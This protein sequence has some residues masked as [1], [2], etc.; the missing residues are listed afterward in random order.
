MTFT[1]QQTALLVEFIALSTDYDE[2]EEDELYNTSQEFLDYIEMTQEEF[3][4]YLNELLE[5]QGIDGLTRIINNY[6]EL[7]KVMY[8]PDEYPVIPEEGT[9]YI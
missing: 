5:T 6:K 4:N 1:T 3:T 9:Y 2:F 7:N 8:S